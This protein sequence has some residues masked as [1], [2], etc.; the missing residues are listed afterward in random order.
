MSDPVVF[1]I[2]LGLLLV[3]LASGVWVAVSLLVVALAGLTFFSNAPTG[4]VLATTLWGH[5]H[6]WP[7][8]AL[9]LFILMGEILLRSSLSKDMFS[10]LAPWLT[11]APGRLLHVNVLGCA[12]FAAVS[13]SSAATAATIGRMSVPELT[14]RGY[15]ESL[16]LGTLAGSATLGFLI[17]PSVILIVYGVA[18]EQSIARLFIAGI[19]PGIM[20]VALFGG[21][22]ALR[23]WM[24]PGLIPVEEAQYSLREKLRAS[25]SL[26]PVVLL[27]GGVIGTIYTGVASPTDAAAVGVLFSLILAVCTGSFSRSDFVEALMSAMRTSAMIAFILLGAAVLSVAMGFT[28]IPRNLAAWI[29]TFGLSSYALLAVLTVFFIVLGCFLD[30]ISVVVLTTS[31]I[32]PMVEAAGID[33]LWFGVYLVLVVEMSQI[34]PPVGFNLFV[35][36][37]L[38][39]S[40]IMKIAKAALPF[41]GLLLLAVLLITLVPGIVTFLPSAMGN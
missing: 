8:A 29:G 39:G 5:S 12:I 17:P 13:G 6:S 16:I 31:I 37:G 11:R 28:G 26:V 4:L 25:R 30:G 15:P 27:I 36:Q 40:N 20:L 3:L 1:S 9:P 23:A 32:L 10:G 2:L 21:Y 24:S 41:F 7:L 14:R 34:T 18:T 22:V 19:L 38:T 33:P 35:I